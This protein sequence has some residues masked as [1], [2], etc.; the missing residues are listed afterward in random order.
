MHV[1]DVNNYFKINLVWVPRV[2]PAHR[3]LAGAKPHTQ[4]IGGIGVVKS[5]TNGTGW[6]LILLGVA[7]M[8]YAH[9]VG[10]A[11]LETVGA[12]FVSAALYAFQH[13]TPEQPVTPKD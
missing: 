8:A 3:P 6:G 7:T 5:I 11:T 13:Q 4:K 9:H 2:A 1:P 12:G 10:F